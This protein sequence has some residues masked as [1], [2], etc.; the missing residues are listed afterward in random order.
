MPINT[1]KIFNIQTNTKPTNTS[2]SQRAYVSSS[3]ALDNIGKDKLDI[4]TQTQKSKSKGL[5][6]WVKATII[7][8]TTTALGL[9]AFFTHGKI[10][11]NQ[12]KKATEEA[13]KLAEETRTKAASAAKDKAA[14]KRSKETRG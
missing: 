12:I 6:K 9:G 1:D 7:A 11:A 5:S 2:V 10:K 8:G 4:S 13:K 3:G 14:K